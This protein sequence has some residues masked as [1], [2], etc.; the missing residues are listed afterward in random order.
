M[1]FGQN[2]ELCGDPERIRWCE[3]ERI[4]IGILIILKGQGHD[5]QAQFRFLSS[6][7]SRGVQ[8]ESSVL[9]VFQSELVSDGVE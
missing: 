8:D 6:A 2:R 3:W 9:E 1:V 4:P 5:G 7:S